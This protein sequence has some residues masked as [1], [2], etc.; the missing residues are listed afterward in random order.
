MAPGN[1]QVYI[2]G[3]TFSQTEESRLLSKAVTPS[4]VQLSSVLDPWCLLRV[5]SSLT[6]ADI[7]SS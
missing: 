7:H 2:Y 6:Q 4:A 5:T 3:I 1:L